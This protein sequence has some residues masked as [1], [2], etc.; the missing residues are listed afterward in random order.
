MLLRV[1]W[2]ETGTSLRRPP[3]AVL[4]ALAL[5]TF[6]SVVFV[7]RPLALACTHLQGARLL[8]QLCAAPSLLALPLAGAVCVIAIA[9]R[10]AGRAKLPAPWLM[11]SVATI[12]GTAAKDELKWMF[13]RPWPDTWL[14]YHVYA[15]HP[16]TDSQSFGSFPSGHTAYIA[17]PLCV[18]WALKPSARPWAGALIGIVMAGLVLA[19]YHFL[20]DVL[21]GLMVGI[22]SAWATLALMA[23]PPNH[24]PQFD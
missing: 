6:F 19:D 16:F 18:L 7:D 22:T 8:F 14:H 9:R 15:L 4:S 2:D 20:A 13:G 11:M 1:G 10:F 23:P 24:V 3:V 21:G 12:A 17:A 5:A